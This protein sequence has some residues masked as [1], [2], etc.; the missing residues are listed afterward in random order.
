MSLKEV[1]EELR[2]RRVGEEDLR[3]E[4][5]RLVD[6]NISHVKEKGVDSVKLLMGRMMEKYRGVADGSTVYRILMEEVKRRLE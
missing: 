2:R 4:A 1:Y 6:E 5:K 3:A